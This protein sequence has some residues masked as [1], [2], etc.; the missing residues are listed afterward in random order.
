LEARKALYCTYIFF[1]LVRMI[2]KRFIS[3]IMVVIAFAASAANVSA[4]TTSFNSSTGQPVTPIASITIDSSKI[5]DSFLFG[6][7]PDPS[8]LATTTELSSY[9]GSQY[10]GDSLMVYRS[11]AAGNTSW[12]QV[13]L[14][15]NT[16]LVKNGFCK[17]VINQNAYYAVVSA[18]AIKPSLSSVFYPATSSLNTLGIGSVVATSTSA[19]STL[20]AS[21]TVT[22]A[23]TSTSASSTPVSTA[24]TATATVATFDYCVTLAGVQSTTDACPVVNGYAVPVSK[25]VTKMTKT[26]MHAGHT[27]T[28]PAKAMV[29]EKPKV[30][31]TVDATNTKDMAMAAPSAVQQVKAAVKDVMQVATSTANQLIATTSMMKDHEGPEKNSKA[32][33][34]LFLALGLLALGL[35][36]LW[37]GRKV[38]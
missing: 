8:K 27:M 33:W 31:L 3:S 26:V 32:K 16:C 2:M 28:M 24:P 37:L 14:L 22:V 25:T 35:W 30:T 6:I 23:A 7:R 19:T 29:A 34:L 10:N 13:D 1:N 36:L 38:R 11:F 21:S 20:T 9:V 4:Q 15:Q 5:V 17:F 18:S 12:S